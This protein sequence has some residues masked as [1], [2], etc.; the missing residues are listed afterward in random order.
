MLDKFGRRVFKKMR[1]SFS[2]AR[3]QD[4]ERFI[5]TE[6]SKYEKDDNTR[7][8]FLFDTDESEIAAF[9]TLSLHSIIL[10]D[11]VSNLDEDTM[12]ILRGYGELPHLAN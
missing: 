2:C 10:G 12:S 3:N 9:F 6:C 11:L 4:V 5:H 7:N 8:Y 1:A